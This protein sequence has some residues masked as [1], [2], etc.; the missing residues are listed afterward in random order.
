[1][2]SKVSK[3]R[4]SSKSEFQRVL[5]SRV[6]QYFSHQQLSRYGDWKLW[7]KSICLCLLTLLVY[8]TI[9]LG[10]YNAR[11]FLCLC[12]L[13]GLLKGSI[14]FI[15]CHDAL[16]GSFSPIPIVNKIGGHLFDLIG[17]SSVIWKIT[18]NYNHHIFTNIAGKDHDID[19]AILLRF[20]PRDPLYP[21][22][23]FQHLYMFF[24]YTLTGLSWIFYGD[25][26]FLIKERKRL[27]FS[28]I[29]TTLAFK[30]LNLCVFLI[31]PFIL[32]PL[33]GWQIL[34]GYLATVM[35]GGFYIAIVFQLAHLVENVSFPIP[36]ENGEITQSWAEHEL[37]TTSNFATSSKWVSFFLGGLNYQ[38]EHHLFAH[39]CHIHY[40]SLSQIVKQTAKEF[41]LPYYEQ[42]SV[43]SAIRSHIKTAKLLGKSS[44]ILIDY[45]VI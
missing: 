26:K 42:E 19:K 28:E 18:H 8:L 37:R 2:T 35:S 10:G 14:G 4:F 45:P 5:K 17:M 15:I 25:Y 21:F 32:I 16:H 13:L 38:I 30:L 23:Q 9:I 20:S 29:G 12:I 7:G 31:A 27:S 22:H 40:P 1:M 24:L 6:D 11:S 36:N 41:H 3:I 33:D 34:I 39:I 44:E 43:L